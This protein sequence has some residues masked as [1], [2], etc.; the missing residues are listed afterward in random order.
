[1]PLGNLAPFEE[2]VERRQPFL[3]VRRRVQTW[4]AR[5]AVESWQSPSLPVEIESHRPD[6][7]VRSALL[8]YEQPGDENKD[9]EECIRIRYRV[10]YAE[11]DDET[12]LVDLISVDNVE[13]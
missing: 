5:L 9:A 1:M 6:Y 3:P 8:C 10:T 11:D 2:W 4:I 7:E 13:S 12:D